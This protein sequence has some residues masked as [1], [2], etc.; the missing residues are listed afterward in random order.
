MSWVRGK[1]SVEVELANI[2]SWI[3]RIDPI[4]NGNGRPGL[5]TVISDY[6]AAEAE[7]QIERKRKEDRNVRMVGLFMAI[8]VVLEI[9]RAAHVIN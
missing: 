4:L 2:Q 9:L 8:P 6:L 7:R 5:L 3:E 1:G